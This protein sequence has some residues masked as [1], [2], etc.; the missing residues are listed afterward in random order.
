MTNKTE[1]F[2]FFHRAERSKKFL[3]DRGMTFDEFW[4]S[5]PEY[6]ISLELPYGINVDKALRLAYT[7]GL[8]RG[9]SRGGCFSIQCDRGIWSHINA[10]RI[11]GAPKSKVNFR[12]WEEIE[13]EG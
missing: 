8:S 4:A 6:S 2:D 10:R 3:E 12:T 7:M 5:V 1:R 9:S 11:D 13:E